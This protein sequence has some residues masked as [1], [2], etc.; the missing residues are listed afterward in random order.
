VK[1]EKVDVFMNV[2]A[3]YLLLPISL[4]V[5]PSGAK[6]VARISGD[7]INF[8]RKTKGLVDMKK[9]FFLLLEKISLNSVDKIAYIDEYMVD[10][11]PPRG[12]P[13]T[14]LPPGI[15]LGVFKPTRSNAK[16]ETILFVGRIHPS[17]GIAELIEAFGLLASK[18][19]R[20]QLFVAGPLQFD[21]KQV[22]TTYTDEE[23]IEYLGVVPNKEL[24][25]LYQEALCLVLP[26]RDEALGN[27]VI[28]A[29]SCGCP[30]IA[31]DTGPIREIVKDAGILLDNNEPKKIAAA[32]EIMLNRGQSSMKK[33]LLDARNRIECK[34]SYRNIR[35]KY[36]NLI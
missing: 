21:I 5:R 1:E 9:L 29:I 35:N 23:R 28:E 26:S 3:Y 10:R 2:W 33:S 32:I 25:T 15:D 17:K 14:I 27:V 7:L 18:Y 34:Y 30:V 16:K 36:A 12:K 6:V 31:T 4:A 20:L 24:V 22:K 8:R 13:Y 11:I 19:K